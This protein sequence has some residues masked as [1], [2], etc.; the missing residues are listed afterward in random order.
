MVKFLKDVWC[1]LNP[2]FTIR[3]KIH[4]ILK[5]FVWKI[6]HKNCSV[7]KTGPCVK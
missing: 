3:K 1:D 7:Y 2:N 6:K 5:A 4:Y